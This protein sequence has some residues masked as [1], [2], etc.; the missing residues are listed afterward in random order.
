MSRLQAAHTYMGMCFVLACAHGL[1]PG[2]LGQEWRSYG[3]DP[4]G[5]RFSPLKQIN[6]TNV[7][8]LQRAWTYRV[9]PSPNS[10]IEAFETTP[11][12]VDD[13]LYFTIQTGHAIAVDA[14]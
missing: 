6:R 13:V 8:Q 11:L 1:A 2:C 3:N 14:E 10:W 4:G 7:R 5:M 9:A 12:M